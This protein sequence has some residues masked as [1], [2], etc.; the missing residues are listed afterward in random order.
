MDSLSPSPGKA[1]G[2]AYLPLFGFNGQN[3]AKSLCI[4]SLGPVAALGTTAHWLYLEVG[5]PGASSLHTPTPSA[6]WV[7]I[8]SNVILGMC[9][10]V[11]KSAE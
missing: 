4:D 5:D 7:D 3:M 9:G 11:F 6:V 2:T 1:D 10:N 8:R